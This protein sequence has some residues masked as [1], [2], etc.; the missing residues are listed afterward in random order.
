MNAEGLRA[1]GDAFPRLGSYV[2]LFQKLAN[3]RN[4][5]ACPGQQRV[6]FIPGNECSIIASEPPRS[7]CAL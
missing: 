5:D 2:A 7:G 6:R 1:Q 3:S 4:G